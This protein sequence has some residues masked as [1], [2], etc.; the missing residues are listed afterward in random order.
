[1]IRVGMERTVNLLSE[2]KNPKFVEKRIMDVVGGERPR[3]VNDDDVGSE[4]RLRVLGFG[5]GNESGLWLKVEVRKGQT[6]CG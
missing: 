2:W 5:C 4:G 3:K 1:M 6:L